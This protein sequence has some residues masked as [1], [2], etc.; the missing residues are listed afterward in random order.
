M[1]RKKIEVVELNKKEEK[2]VLE[3]K[4]SPLILFFRRNRL[5]IFL[6]LLILSLTA[7]VLGVLIN[8]KYF[9]KSEEPIIK[10]VT[11]DTTLDNYLAD[12]TSNG[13]MSEETA[14][15]LFSKNSTFKN[16]GEVLL[17]ETIETNAYTIK[18]FSDGTALKIMKQGNKVTRIGALK[19]GKYGITKDGVID[20]KAIIS[21][22]KV[23]DTKY[24]DWG[25]VTYYSDGSAEVTNSKMDIFVRNAKD[26]NKNYISDN[27]VA[28][29]KETKKVGNITLNYYYDGTIEVIK[30]GKS[31]LVRTED[32]LNITSND[33][34]F[35]NNNEASITSSKKLSDGKTIDYYQDGG[36]II[37]D[38]DKTLSVRKSNS[39]VIKDNKVF[40][41]VDSIYV[42]VSKK[43][44][45]ATYYTNGS[46]VIDYN[47]KTYYI[48]ENSNIKYGNNNNIT[49]VEKNKEN[50]ANE[51]NR[52]NENVKTFENHAVIT[53]KDYIAIIP[54]DAVV[55]DENGKIK[56]IDA[57]SVSNDEDTDENSNSFN[58]TNNT[59]QP[60]K[61]RVVIEESPR[62]TVD[63]KY[64][65][66]MYSNSS[67]ISKPQ[68]LEKAKWQAD[69]ISSSLNIQG[70]NYILIDSTIEP[71]DTENISVML[72]ADYDTIPNAM[73]DKYFY[74]TIKV[75]AWME[76]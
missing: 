59:N 15:K 45:K 40:E 8:I 25:T 57:V 66:Y 32:D 21:D 42:E 47:G 36:A 18:Y 64:L 76:E 22:V 30:N 61:Y 7:I 24:Y 35:K 31:Y 56:G 27:K 53:T 11:I 70:T 69:N 3:E 43:T 65:R 51:T 58:I 48:E 33:V 28:Y 16:K 50:L 17:V 20:S 2:I 63:V 39:I 4:Q 71:H 12:I 73:Q 29:L 54:A 67:G 23:K 55:Y 60:L 46:A 34:T 74:G 72:W 9:N 6:T 5:L 14:Q 52:Y 62:T 75:Y 38:G 41:I 13:A 49:N 19:N 44:D 26:I 68:E 37:R 1:S 10:E